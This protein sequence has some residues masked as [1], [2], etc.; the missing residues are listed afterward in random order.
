MFQQISSGYL[1]FIPCKNRGLEMSDPT[2][3]KSLM[4]LC[5]GHTYYKGLTEKNVWH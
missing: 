5:L 3:N 1:L 4:Y 2:K